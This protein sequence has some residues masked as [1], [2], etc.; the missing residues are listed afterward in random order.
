LQEFC[1]IQL[2]STSGL[3]ATANAVALAV[4]SQTTVKSNIRFMISPPSLNNDDPVGIKQ[5]QQR[6]IPIPLGIARLCSVE[7]PHAMGL[8]KL[9]DCFSQRF[10][11]WKNVRLQYDYIDFIHFLFH[12]KRS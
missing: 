12:P 4:A 10:P 8:L 9:L 2:V 7:T 3:S 5:A 11:V 6:L 1:L